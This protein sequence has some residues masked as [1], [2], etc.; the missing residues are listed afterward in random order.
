MRPIRKIVHKSKYLSTTE[1]SPRMLFSIPLLSFDAN[2]DMLDI[3][4][5]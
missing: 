2:F 5:N 4:L 3:L 1:K